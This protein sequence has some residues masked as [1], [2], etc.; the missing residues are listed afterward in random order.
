MLTLERMPATGALNWAPPKARVILR[1]VPKALG[2]PVASDGWCSLARLEG[3]AGVAAGGGMNGDFAV[4]LSGGRL[5]L[6]LK[7]AATAG[8]GMQGGLTFQVGYEAIGELLNL[9]RRELHNNQ[10]RPL[11]WVTPQA[12]TF[13]SRLNTV[14]ALG[15]DVGMVYLLNLLDSQANAALQAVDKVMG[16]YEA[17]TGGGKGGPIAY[18]ILNYENQAEL[19]LW[20]VEAMPSALGPMLM[21][22]LSEPAEFDVEENGAT[23]TK[24]K[25]QSHLFQQQAIERIL[26]WIV[27]NA[28]YTN[29]IRQ[30]QKQFD[31][32]CSRMDRF[33]ALAEKP[34]QA[35]CENRRK[36][37]R[38][39]AVVPNT[40]DANNDFNNSMRESYKKHE[41]V[42]GALR[43]GYCRVDK[44]YGTD[45]LASV[46]YTGP[47]E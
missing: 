33:G 31:E 44:Y 36:M 14:G 42:L 25:Q 45:Y 27:T 20:F 22:L 9:V 46:T 39:M 34:G 37:D 32:A 3:S 7:G 2:N 30:A 4:S 6:H 38:F 17:I 24:T 15:L 40:P 41:E 13:L 8:F 35:Y 21:T 47:G 10:Q 18:A 23:V 16:L 29:R 43:D 11:Q 26:D 5:L 19:E 12:M 1:N 28:Q